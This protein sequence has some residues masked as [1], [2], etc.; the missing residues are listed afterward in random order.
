[1]LVRYADLCRARHTVFL[2]GLTKVR[3]SD[4]GVASSLVNVGRQVGGSIGL[5]VVAP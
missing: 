5:A 2:V 3:D 4:A 1:M